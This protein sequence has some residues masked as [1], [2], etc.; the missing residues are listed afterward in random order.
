MLIKYI[1]IH[2]SAVN[3]IISKIILGL[4]G[5]SFAVACNIL[6]FLRR[7]DA[8]VKSLPTGLYQISQ[9]GVTQH[10]K[11]RTQAY[12]V[13]QRGLEARAQQIGEV[14]FL[15]KIDI[16]N[17]DLVIDC[18]ANVGDILLYFNIKGIRIKYLGYEPSPEEY[19]A[20]RINVGHSSCKNEG[21]WNSNSEIM[22][23]VSSDGAD[24]SFIEP[25]TYTKTIAIA[26]KR[27]D[28]EDFGRIKV[29]KIEAEGAEPE[30]LE[31]ALGILNQVEYITADLG[32]ERGKART[33]TFAPVSNFLMKNGFELVG[34]SHG[35]VCA[36]FRNTKI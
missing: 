10:F 2:I 5:N 22:F 9:N 21:L 12:N 7:V 17:D 24:S 13:Y 23:Y 15:D 29:L 20:L 8:R 3:I 33:S 6:Y 4:R 14:Y 18:G 32:F 30:V 25:P 1:K 35:R 16:K 36:L 28:S 11:N 31:G 27:L 26:T 34:V 19:S